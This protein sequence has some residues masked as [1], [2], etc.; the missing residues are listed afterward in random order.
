MC[1]NATTPEKINKSGPYVENGTYEQ[2]VTHLER[3][4]ELNGLEAPDELPINNVSQQTTNTNSD[5]H[6]PTCHHCKKPGHCRNQCQLLK[7]QR[8]QSENNQKNLETKTVPPKPL[9]GTTMPII[10]VTTKTVTEPKKGLE[11]F[12]HPVRHVGKQTTPQKN[13]TMEPMQPIDRLPGKEDR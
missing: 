5:R 10:I 9:T 8:E 6:K 2:I 7:K 4:L 1:Q 13:A 3:E 11:V 12:T